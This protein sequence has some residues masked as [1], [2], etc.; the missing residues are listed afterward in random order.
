[1]KAVVQAERVTGK[2]RSGLMF[3]GISSLFPFIP[4][5]YG[6]LFKNKMI[7]KV[8]ELVVYIY[9]WERWV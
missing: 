7:F 3:L 1:M 6:P 9:R 8:E 5:Q 2:R 4:L